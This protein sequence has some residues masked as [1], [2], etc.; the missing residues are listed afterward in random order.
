VSGGRAARAALLAGVA[1]AG[2]L[3][4]WPWLRPV[5]VEPLAL[6]TWLLLRLFVLSV[7]QAAWWTG[8]VLVAAGALL[9]LLRRRALPPPSP[10]PVALLLP[11]GPVEAWRARLARAA[12][13][14]PPAPTLGWDAFLQLAVSLRA[15]ELRVP[16]DHRLHDALRDGAVPLPAGVHAH[17]FPAAPPRAWTTR[18]VKERS[19][20]LRRL[21]TGRDRAERLERLSQLLTY[22]EDSLEMPHHDPPDAH[23]PRPLDA[24]RPARAGPAG[25]AGSG[26]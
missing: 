15:L 13:G 18:W 4:A 20:A 21:L 14:V 1:L 6:V 22:L 10:P 12:A 19:A 11:K 17:L 16:A 26:S 23:A 7:H 25:P 8:L 24:P 9:A 5:L 2:L 3:A